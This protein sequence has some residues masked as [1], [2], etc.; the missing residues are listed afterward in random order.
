MPK[1]TSLPFPLFSTLPKKKPLPPT[2]NGINP[3]T[4][5]RRHRLLRPIKVHPTV[6]KQPAYPAAAHYIRA[7][8]P[9]HRTPVILPHGPTDCAKGLLL[10]WLP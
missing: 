3:T 9:A 4:L 7:I 2:V 5:P 10:P 8:A 6:T 1:A